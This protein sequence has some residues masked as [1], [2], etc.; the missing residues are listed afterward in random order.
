MV[1]VDADVAP[2][3]REVLDSEGLNKTS[4]FIMFGGERPEYGPLAETLL[5]PTGTEMNFM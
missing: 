2:M 4:M 1:L 5:K 3:V